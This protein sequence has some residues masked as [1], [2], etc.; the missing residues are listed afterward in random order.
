[1]RTLTI[2]DDAPVSWSVGS[3]PRELTDA[4]KVVIGP[5]FENDLPTDTVL[6]VVIP[7]APSA[8]SEPARDSPSREVVR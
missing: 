7:V 8:S 4:E 6:W 1:M 5:Y 3:V 2:P